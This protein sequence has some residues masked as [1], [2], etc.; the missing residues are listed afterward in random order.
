M[1][2]K[3][4]RSQGTFKCALLIE[5]PASEFHQGQRLWP[6]SKSESMAAISTYLLSSIERLAN[7]GR[8][9]MTSV[10]PS[11]RLT[12]PVAHGRLNRYPRVIRVTF[13]LMPVGYT[14]QRSVQVLGFGN[15]GYL[16]PLHRLIRFF[17]LKGG[18]RC[19]SGQH[20]ASGFLQIRSRPRHPCLWLTLPLAG[21]IEDFH[22]Q[23]TNEATIATLVALAR[24]APCLAHQ[25]KSP[26]MRRIWCDRTL[27][28]ILFRRPDA[29]SATAS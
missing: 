22:P 24:N 21:C 8:P 1:A 28:A 23:V 16:T 29:G 27:S 26:A 17:P 3:A 20:F 25:K 11:R 5:V 14:S 12:A 2:G 4:R 15:F 19:S 10:R 7:R 9:S 18:P 13:L 6:R